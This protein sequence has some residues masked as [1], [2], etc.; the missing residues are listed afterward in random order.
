MVGMRME[1]ALNAF[2]SDQSKVTFMPQGG[3]LGNDQ[4]LCCKRASFKH[5]P[6]C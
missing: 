3:R 1:K 6:L 5:Q 4:V 2:S